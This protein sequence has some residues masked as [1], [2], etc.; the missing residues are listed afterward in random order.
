LSLL[1]CL[2]VL[3]MAGPAPITA[4]SVGAV[5]DKMEAQ[6]QRQ[7]SAVNTFIAETNHYTSCYEKTTR[8][9]RPTYR[10]AP[11]QRWSWT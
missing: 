11:P 4:Q 1:L 3:G 7:L 9:G 2:I 8:D 6:C 10:S 5:V